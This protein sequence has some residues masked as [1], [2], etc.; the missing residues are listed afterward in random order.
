MTE[1]P[2]E[3]PAPSEPAPSEPAP[4]ERVATPPPSLRRALA[5]RRTRTQLLIGSLFVLLGFAVAVQVGSNRE[6][7]DLGRTNESD[8]VRI[9]DD[10]NQREGRLQAELRDLEVLRERL[11]TGTDAE[12]IALEESKN[13]VETLSIL[14]GT[15]PATG[16]GVLVRLADPQDAVDAAL[17]LDTVQELRDAGAEALQLGDERIVVSTWFADPPAGAEGVL[18]SGVLVRAPYE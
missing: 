8:L 4:T 1:T 2:G 3:Q 10:V 18:V 6:G 15:V 17:V 5:F 16:P 14:A 7:V 12:T 9:L 11:A 13:R